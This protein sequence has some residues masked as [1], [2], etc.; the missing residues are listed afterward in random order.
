MLFE[1]GM[2][3]GKVTLCGGFVR[4]AL[5]MR[6][7]LG[8]RCW[9]PACGVVLLGCWPEWSESMRSCQMFGRAVP[10]SVTDGK[11]LACD[12]RLGS[13]KLKDEGRVWPPF[14]HI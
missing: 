7:H 4:G 10:D 11:S 13:S 3:D 14:W 2:S 5:H 1:A 9:V 12:C 6:R 8:Q